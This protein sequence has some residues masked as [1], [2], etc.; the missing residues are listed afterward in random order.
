MSRAYALSVVARWAGYAGLHSP[1]VCV[2]RWLA[3]RPRGPL[4]ADP[5]WLPASCF[6]RFPRSNLGGWHVVGPHGRALRL[7]RAR[8]VV[9]AAALL[10]KADNADEPAGGQPSSSNGKAARKG[11]AHKGAA[12]DKAPA[13]KKRRAAGSEPAAGS[14]VHA[15]KAGGKG[16]AAQEPLQRAAV[17]RQEEDDEQTP[18]P[19]AQ[20]AAKRRK[21]E[22][23]GGGASGVQ[24]KAK[25][26]VARAA[27]P[28]PAAA[29][30]RKAGGKHAKP[31]ARKG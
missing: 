17:Q 15:G 18:A 23:A 14:K 11:K 7:G 13:A 21:G 24:A 1:V 16:G 27:A 8:D 5:G 6:A 4:W 22:P 2:W 30:P 26:S 9:A 25:S 31:K 20:Q 29:L 28:A 10:L 19:A 12:A 3:G